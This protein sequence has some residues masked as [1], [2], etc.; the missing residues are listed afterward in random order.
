MER[1]PVLAHRVLWSGT[2]MLLLLLL[3]FEAGKQGLSNF[4]ALSADLAVERWAQRRIKGEERARVVRHL[5]KSL[6]YAPDN[7]WSLE[8]LGAVQLA[9]MR[10]SLDPQ[11]A[12]AAA[13]SAN[14]NFRRALIERPTS[15]FVWANFALSKLYL[16]EQD[17][18]FFLAIERAGELGP[19]EP[20][21][22]RVV[23][24]AGLSAWNRLNPAQRAAVLGAMQRGARR[25]PGRIAEMARSFNRIDLFCA[26]RYS[27]SQ[28]TEF[29][30]QPGGSGSKP[31]RKQ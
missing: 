7:P 6:E 10:T 21:V 18:A 29:C 4:Y 14:A 12:V 23:I 25:D 1:P 5:E 11:A 2:L 30:R 9:I 15:P 22:Q 17:Q 31:M 19:W 26:L 13:R 20:A 28:G 24:S 3:A 16:E 27:R 8:E